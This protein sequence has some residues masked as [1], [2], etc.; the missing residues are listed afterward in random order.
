MSPDSR[1]RPGS[2]EQVP[3]GSGK[4]APVGAT[5]PGA[6]TSAS[7]GVPG[8]IRYGDGPV[9]LNSGRE[10]TT[11][12]VVNTGDR[13]VTVG[14]HYHFAEANP[15]LEF[16]REAAWGKHQNI[17]AGGMTRFDPGTVT[18]V[19]L[20]P[21]AGRRIAAGFRGECEGNLDD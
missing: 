4:G 15:A 5:Q 7:P 6:N 16:D 11:V 10:V 20:V 21:F 14:S 12:R 8:E 3:L 9:V 19:A 1:K 13:P 2:G 17:L 18:E